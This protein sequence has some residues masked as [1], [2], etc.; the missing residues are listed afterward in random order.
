MVGR[1]CGN[2]SDIKEKLASILYLEIATYLQ[3]FL[4]ASLGER[5]TSRNPTPDLRS[6]MANQYRKIKRKELYELVWTKP[7][8]HLAK[9]FGCSDVGLRK[10]CVKHNIPLPRVGHWAR[11]AAGQHSIQLRLPDAA[12]NPDIVISAVAANLREEKKKESAEISE[13]HAAF[14]DITELAS[15]DHIDKPHPL[16]KRTQEILAQYR[17]KIDRFKKRRDGYLHLSH[18]NWPPHEDK[19]RYSFHVS[20]GALPIRA[21]LSMVERI[22]R[23]LDPLLKVLSNHDFKFSVGEDRSNRGKILLVEKDGERMTFSITEGYSWSKLSDEKMAKYESRTASAN[24]TINFYVSGLME[25]P[26]KTFTSGRGKTIDSQASSILLM[27]LNMP[28]I[29]RETRLANER[30]RA[31]YERISK[32]KEHNRAIGRNQYEQVDIAIKESKLHLD[33]IQLRQYLAAVRHELGGRPKEERRLGEFWIKIVEHFVSERDP[34]KRRIKLFEELGDPRK[35]ST[36][37]YW[38]RKEIPLQTANSQD[39]DDDQED[40]L[41]EDTW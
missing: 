34:L 15:V 37:D 25:G 16:V 32:I 5:P 30:A 31:E 3:G 38:H 8:T 20:D 10:I 27:F 28:K 41:E 11:V 24:G 18:E 6:P 26:S 29:Q 17:V 9:E 13:L 2:R 39:E 33:L 22:L 40:E 14:P 7:M 35:S 23:F 21:S 12:S 1:E 4:A 19:G 36:Q